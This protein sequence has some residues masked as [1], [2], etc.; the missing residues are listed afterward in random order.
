MPFPNH[1]SYWLSVLRWLEPR[2]SPGDTLMAPD[3]F[4]EHFRQI[5]RYEASLIDDNS[6]HDWIVFHKGH[7][8]RVHPRYLANARKRCHTVF[9]NEVFVILAKRRGSPTLSKNN[10]HWQSFV[11]FA[12]NREKLPPPCPIDDRPIALP[13]PKQLTVDQIREEMNRRY[14]RQDWDEYGGYEFQ[15]EWDRVRFHDMEEGC[16]KLLGDVTNKSILEMACGL[17]RIVPLV[18]G[19]ADYLGLD[20]S[21]VAIE[22]AR[23]KHASRPEVTFKQADSTRSNLPDASFDIVLAFEVIEHVLEPELLLAEAYRM[24]KP[25]G[26]F[27]VN[28]ANRDSLH[29]RMLRRLGRPDLLATKEHVCEFGFKEM[30]GILERIGFVVRESRGCFLLPYYAIPELDQHVGQITRDDPETVEMFRLLGERAGAEFAFEYMIAAEK[31]I[32]LS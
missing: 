1:D 15:H 19:C 32:A 6:V 20:L 25:G 26:R 7:L 28:S 21:D 24:L 22:R 31:L 5:H 10:P 2:L 17:G 16:L 4:A 13:T 12:I 9:A 8:E 18:T 27:V 14:R 29:L 30:C 11:Q 3:E 23:E